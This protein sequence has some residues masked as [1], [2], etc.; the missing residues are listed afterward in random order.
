MKKREEKRIRE[1]ERNKV[2]E[3]RE[4]VKDGQDDIH[5][6]DNKIIVKVLI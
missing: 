2:R 4:Q 6:I 5:I 3:T 1:N